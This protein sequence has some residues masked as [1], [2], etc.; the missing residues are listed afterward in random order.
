MQGPA[1]LPPPSLP[2]TFDGD[3]ALSLAQELSRLHPN[4]APGTSGA[5]GAADWL[6]DKMRF[7]GFRP[8]ANVHVDAFTDTFEATIPGRGRVPLRNLG[9]VVKGRSTDTIVVMA[10][11]DD[12]GLGAGANDNASGTAALLE[13]ARIYAPP[14]T[15]DR[16]GGTG[17]H[18]PLPL[19]RRRRLR[20]HRG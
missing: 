6:T 18:D 4:R 20:G 12:S 9:F 11:R 14:V 2:P 17:A 10:H 13:L 3:S 15:A 5:T 19:H 7:F 8:N 16:A 1:A